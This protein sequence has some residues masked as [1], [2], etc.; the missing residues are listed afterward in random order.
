MK[1]MSDTADPSPE[2]PDL[3]QSAHLLQLGYEPWPDMLACSLLPHA[4][5]SPVPAVRCTVAHFP[6]GFP[7]A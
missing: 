2:D 6:G 7:G 4:R 1:C 5:H 3:S